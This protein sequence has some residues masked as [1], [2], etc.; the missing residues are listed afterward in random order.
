MLNK[1]TI[2]LDS[3]SHFLD[4]TLLSSILDQVSKGMHQLQINIEALILILVLVH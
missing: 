2:C 4:T 3:N 1:C